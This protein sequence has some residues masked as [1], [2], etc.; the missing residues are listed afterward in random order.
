MHWKIHW[1]HWMEVC[2][3]PSR[4]CT[5]IKMVVE[6]EVLSL[7][8]YICYRFFLASKVYNSHIMPEQERLESYFTTYLAN[9][10]Y[11]LSG[12]LQI[13]CLLYHPTL[14]PWTGNTVSSMSAELANLDRQI[15]QGTPITVQVDGRLTRH[16]LS[17]QS[18]QWPKL[19]VRYP[20]TEDG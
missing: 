10:I 14:Q 7:L 4:R 15:F 13:G 19:Q 20:L 8:E 16:E 17:A 11:F 18:T 6:V 1:I 12:G 3:R 2:R 9:C 5:I